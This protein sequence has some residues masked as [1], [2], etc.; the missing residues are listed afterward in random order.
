MFVCIKE[1]EIYK[2][3]QISRKLQQKVNQA[4][5]KE[6]NCD[7]V[8]KKI[9]PKDISGTVIVNKRP[10]ESGQWRKQPSTRILLK[11]M[12]YLSSDRK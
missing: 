6:K 7:L 2:G 9:T 1:T 8:I 4:A 10:L 3:H 12:K 11:Y 5:K